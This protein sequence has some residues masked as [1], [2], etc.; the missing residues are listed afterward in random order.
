MDR[1]AFGY[2][3]VYSDIRTPCS[4]GHRPLQ[5]SAAVTTAAVAARAVA[6]AAMA[7][8]A[9][10]A[11]VVAADLKGRTMFPPLLFIFFYSVRSSAKIT[12]FPLKFA[13]IIVT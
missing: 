5:A 10:M 3:D 11:A 9:A 6:V 13:P 8:A 7:V 12:V 4:L 2:S 1:R